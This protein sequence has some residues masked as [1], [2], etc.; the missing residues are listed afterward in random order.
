MSHSKN[1]FFKNSNSEAII[2][3]DILTAV[4]ID[5]NPSF[6]ISIIL[7]VKHES[8][9]ILFSMDN[10]H[11]D[12]EIKFVSYNKMYGKVMVNIMSDRQ[13]D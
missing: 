5:I 10:V 13:T 9:E 4:S 12:A 2:P 7:P 8:L 11:F 6:S 1:T 3:S